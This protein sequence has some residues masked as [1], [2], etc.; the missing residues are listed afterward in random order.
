L[1]PIYAIFPRQSS[2][3]SAAS[4]LYAARCGLLGRFSLLAA[5]ALR[6]HAS[7]QIARTRSDFERFSEMSENFETGRWREGDL[8]FQYPSFDRV[9]TGG[10]E[11][12]P[13]S[14]ESGPCSRDLELLPALSLSRPCGR[15]IALAETFPASA[16][17]PLDKTWSKVFAAAIATD[18]L[19]RLWLATHLIS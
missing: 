14:F 12:G 15:A 13:N 8:D 19:A 6:V 16:I 10:K 18:Q 17:T 1:A 7:S 5:A 3:E 4:W 2:V 9:Q 11:Q